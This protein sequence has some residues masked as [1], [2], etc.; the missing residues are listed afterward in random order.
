MLSSMSSYVTLVGLIFGNSVFPGGLVWEHVNHTH[1]GS[2]SLIAPCANWST[3]G[4]TNFWAKPKQKGLLHKKLKWYSLCVQSRHRSYQPVWFPTWQTNCFALKG[5]R[6]TQMCYVTN[7]DLYALP[8]QKQACSP[9]TPHAEK[10]KSDPYITYIY[11]R[12]ILIHSM[13]I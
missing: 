8:F 10:T 13:W 1:P 5:P 6:A 11:I 3:G 2:D 4:I 7:V 9:Y 12:L